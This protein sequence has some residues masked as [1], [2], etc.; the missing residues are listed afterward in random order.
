MSHTEHFKWWQKVITVHYWLADSYLQGFLRSR[1]KTP[2]NSCVCLTVMVYLTILEHKTHKSGWAFSVWR[3]TVCYSREAL[4]SNHD[5]GRV[6]LGWSGAVY[7][8]TEIK[9]NC[10]GK[11][12]AATQVVKTSEARDVLLKDSRSKGGERGEGGEGEWC[13]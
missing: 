9:N 2:I 1:K 3:I 5:V 10:G 13:L 7:D 6:F 4:S 11:Q 12:L 8:C